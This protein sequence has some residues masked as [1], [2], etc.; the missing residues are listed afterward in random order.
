MDGIIALQRA[1]KQILA[2]PTPKTVEKTIALIK[3]FNRQD[4]C[5]CSLVF[6]HAKTINL[7]TGAEASTRSR[8]NHNQHCDLWDKWCNPLVPEMNAVNEAI[9][10][11]P[12]CDLNTAYKKYVEAQ[13]EDCIMSAIGMVWPFEPQLNLVNLL[14][15]KQV[16]ECSSVLDFKDSYWPLQ[17][18]GNP[19]G[20]NM[21]ENHYYKEVSNILCSLHYPL[22]ASLR[23][24]IYKHFE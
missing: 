7:L 18:A 24:M 23:G 21:D 1:V 12:E 22:S 19:N 6:V 14:L 2:L 10:A 8:I 11:A 3:S 4:D 15:C 13:I 17:W 20:I 16:Y 5:T 9:I